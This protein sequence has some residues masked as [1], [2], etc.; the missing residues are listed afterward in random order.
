M[1][2]SNS[3]NILLVDDQPAKLLAYEAVLGDLGENLIKA[4][5]AREALA[6]LLKNDVAII[7]IDVCMPEQDG[8]ELAETIRAHPRF[9]KTA[10]I[11]ISGVQ[12]SEADRERGYSLGA[13]DYVPVPVEPG[14]LRAKIRVF[15]ELHRK[16]RELERLNRELESRVAE[17][18]AELSASNARLQMAIDVARLG[19]WD[20]D[21]ETGELY[22]SDMHYELFGYQ[23]GEVVPSF[24]AWRARVHPDDVQAAE[25][26]IVRS[27]D[28]CKPYHVTYRSVRPD[29][30]FIWCDARGQ[31]A[32]GY[33]GRPIRMLGVVKDV[34]VYKLADERQK[35]TLRELHHRVKNTLATVQAITNLTSRTS[36][37]LQDFNIAF[38]DRIA[39]LSR[40][41][42]VLVDGN[43]QCIQLRELL[44][45]E[46]SSFD[47]GTSKR[48]VLAGPSIDLPSEFALSLGLAFHE[49][50]TNAAKYGALSVREGRISIEW[51]VARSPADERM[52]HL[53]WVERGGPALRHPQR[54]GFG[55]TLLEKLFS[56]QGARSSLEFAQTGVVFDL[57]VPLAEAASVPVKSRQGN[58][59]RE[60]P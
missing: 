20:W 34:S 60:F 7:L 53:K 9:Q 47:D 13:V 15:A 26:E 37:D 49:L 32:Q 29:G 14:L 18:T 48:I 36:Y 8:F 4:G 45:N 22:W 44:E 6:Q 16:T 21:I 39:S 40:T 42:T 3:I 54:R 2:G 30:S 1:S 41:H 51:A 23:P 55:S 31:Y 50:A 56:A 10:I 27:R 38:A 52:L 24:K 17:R 28:T 46:L 43:W 57:E 12:M 25:S 59:H 58:P 33:D 35:L 19:T 5:S 11:F